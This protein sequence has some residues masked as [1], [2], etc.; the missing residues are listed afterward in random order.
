MA[1][2]SPFPLASVLL[3][4]SLLQPEIAPAQTI[5]PVAVNAPG[6]A[7]LF[8]SAQPPEKVRI[9]LKNNG[10]VPREFKFVKIGRAHV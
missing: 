5:D 8:S 7:P 2:A 10:L 4:T 3:M 9:R 1:F 6:L